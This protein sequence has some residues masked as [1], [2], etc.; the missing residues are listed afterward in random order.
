[1]ADTGVF[2]FELV[3]LDQLIKNM[4][5]LPTFAMRKTVVRNA[6]KK[7]LKPVM[8][9]AKQAAPVG[10]TGN[11]KRS[12]T[13]G[14]LMPRHRPRGKPRDRTTVTVY[15]GAVSPHAWLVEFGSKERTL[16]SQSKAPIGGGVL[17][18]RSTGRMPA[19]PFMRNAWDTRK[20]NLLQTFA[21]EMKIQLEK[22]AA[23]LAKRAGAGTLT[24]S[25]IKGLRG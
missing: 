13:I 21:K 2:K 25:Q 15:V 7:S 10:P 12:I 1:V 8:E 14:R 3:G 23:R 20:N 19:N 4:E 17:T 22:A 9:A 5:E 24:K 16:K 11:L 6:L 18:V